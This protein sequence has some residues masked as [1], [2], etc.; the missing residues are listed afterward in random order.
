VPV[1]AAKPAS[2]LHFKLVEKA[3]AYQQAF[4]KPKPNG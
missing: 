1:S 3:R 2:S 4:D